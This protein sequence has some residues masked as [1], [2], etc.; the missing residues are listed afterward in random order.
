MHDRGDEPAAVAQ[1]RRHSGKDARQVV[2]VHQRQLASTAVE[3]PPLPPGGV[4]GDVRADI[5]ISSG[6]VARALLSMAAEMSTPVT[7]APSR[8][9]Y[10]LIRPWPQAMSS[11]RSPVTVGSS[12]ECAAIS[13]GPSPIQCSYH[14]ANSSYLAGA[15]VTLFR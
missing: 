4:S 2:D 1:D 12:S 5:A 14:S 11:T 15:C 8:A 3:G 6:L 9:R 13:G 7:S 10:R